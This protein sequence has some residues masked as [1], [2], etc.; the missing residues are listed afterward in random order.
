M[1]RRSFL[2][3]AGGLALPAM[4]QGQRLSA[5]CR[6]GLSA[7]HVGRAV[8]ARDRARALSPG[9]SPRTRAAAASCARGTATAEERWAQLGACRCR[10]PAARPAVL[11][12]LHGER[13]GEP[14]RPHAHRAGAERHAGGAA[15]RLR[16]VPAV[17]AGLLRRLPPHGGRGARRRAVRRRLHLR[18]VVGPQPGAP[19]HRRALHA[20][21][22]I[23]RPLRA[24][25]VRR[26]PAGRARRAS[27]DRHLGRPRGRPTTTPATSARSDPDP[28]RFLQQRAA[29]YQAYWEHMP[30]PNAL[31]PDG[32]SL[33]LYDRYRFGDARRA[34]RARRPPV[35]LAPRLPRDADRAASRWRTAPSGSIPRAPCWAPS[36]RRGSPTACA[37]PRRAGTSSRSRP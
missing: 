19:S 6:V 10:G 36:R 16:L 31:R 12:S 24:V 37:A 30:L 28:A 27:L 32:P 22:R 21:R 5:R 11:V 20:A 15:L 14:G 34:A 4:A 18:D 33:R 1:L 23:S 9:R 3:G 25:Q 26:R 7:S 29:A 2:V 17:R 8:D 13:P 35:P